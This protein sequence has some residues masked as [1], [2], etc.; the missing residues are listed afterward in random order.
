MPASVATS[1][2]EEEDYQPVLHFIVDIDQ[3]TN[4]GQSWQQRE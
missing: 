1:E 3:L 2:Q 4:H